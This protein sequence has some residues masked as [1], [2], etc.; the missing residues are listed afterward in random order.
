MYRDI[1]FGIDTDMKN[2]KVL[3]E[4]AKLSGEGTVVTMINMIS[5]KDIQA[6]VRT[7]VHFE[8]MT[9]KRQKVFNMYLTS[10]M[11]ETLNII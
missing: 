2:E 5:E 6:S 10:L 8:E 9:E 3:E 1:L 11:N 4:I 7:G